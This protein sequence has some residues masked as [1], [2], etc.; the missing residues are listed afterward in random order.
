MSQETRS[1][2]VCVPRWKW[3][4]RYT[5]IHIYIIFFAWFPSIHIIRWFSFLFVCSFFLFLFLSLVTWKIYALAIFIA[6]VD[7]QTHISLSFFLSL[8]HSLSLSLFA[9]SRGMKKLVSNRRRGDPRGF[10]ARV[11]AE[12]VGVAA[13]SMPTEISA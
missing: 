9:T 1:V 13:Y 5:R 3:R 7:C 12:I 2:C 11:A 4:E 6:R 8:T 10:K